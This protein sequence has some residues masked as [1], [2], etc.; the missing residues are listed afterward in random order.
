M[1]ASVEFPA[2]GFLIIG[3]FGVNKNMLVGKTLIN[4]LKSPKKR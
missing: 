3:I 1:F 4:L 2:Q